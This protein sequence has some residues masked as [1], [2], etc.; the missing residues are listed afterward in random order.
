M[1]DLGWTEILVI[2]VVALIV[3][4]PR[5]LPVALHTFGKYIAKLKAMARDFQSG[6]DDIARQHE[7]KELQEG[8]NKF[9]SPEQA[10]E[11][12][13]SGLENQGAK[14]VAPKAEEPALV[15]PESE[16]KIA[17]EAAGDVEDWSA[18]AAAAALPAA[19]SVAGAAPENIQDEKPE[20]LQG[21]PADVRSDAG[22][23]VARGNDETT[24]QSAAKKPTEAKPGH[25]TAS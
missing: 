8:I 17:G 19:L 23:K 4:G 11:K 12:Y 9:S 5:D 15:E 1:L 21:V 22:E 14:P 24:A 18:A 13:V 20:P 16:N 6:I 10:I 7:L 3:I 25:T 2:G